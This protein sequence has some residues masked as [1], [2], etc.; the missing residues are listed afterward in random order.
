MQYEDSARIVTIIK[1][2]D[3]LIPGMR[4]RGE[5]VEQMVEEVD[6]YPSL[7]ALHWGE[8]RKHENPHLDST[9][10]A[11]M[12]SVYCPN[13]V[14]RGAAQATERICLS[15]GNEQAAV[16]LDLEGVSWIP[17]LQKSGQASAGK[18]RV[19]SQY[20]HSLS[21]QASTHGFKNISGPVMGY[22]MRTAEYR[23]TEWAAFPCGRFLDD[24]MKCTSSSD[25]R[26]DL[27]YVRAEKENVSNRH[28]RSHVIKLLIYQDRPWIATGPFEQ[29]MHDERLT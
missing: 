28:S 15:D 23:Y 2:A 4:K 10:K 22:S 1:P 16:P 14:E 5:I 19:F 27:V 11:A 7:V 13:Q 24:P 9:R 25:P 17:L 8:V 20:P 3:D 26:W 21:Y 12:S 6:I 18:P 29:D